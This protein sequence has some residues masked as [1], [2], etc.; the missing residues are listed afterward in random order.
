MKI[1]FVTRFL[2]YSA[3]R[4]SGAQDTYHYIAALSKDHDISLI[5][6]AS[7]E[8]GRATD[9]VR[10]ICRQVVT[11]PYQPDAFLPRLWRL[12]WRILLPRVYGRNVSINYWRSLR[13]LYSA[14][15][16][17][18]IVVDGMMAIYCYALWDSPLV[19]DEVDLYATV[20]HQNFGKE[21]RLFFRFLAWLDWRRTRLFEFHTIR[22][23]D[24]IFV[25]STKDRTLLH[26]FVPG[27]SIA[28]IGPWF[29]GLSE[30]QTIPLER[31]AGNNVLFIGAMHT[32]KNVE[33]VLYFAGEVLPLI[34]EKVP[35]AVFYVVGSEPTGS[36][37]DLN[38]QSNIVV[39]GEVESL[40]PYY[41]RCAVNVVPLLVGGGIIVKTLNGMAAGRPTV[42][43]D[44]GNSGIGAI[45]DRDLIISDL[46]P[47]KY[48][49]AVIRL[50]EDRLLWERLAS[51]GRHFIKQQYNWVDT[52]EELE[53]FLRNIRQQAVMN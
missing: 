7:P 39:T 45:S 31:P 38:Q 36:I 24:G 46:H 27:K 10:S 8:I 43:T 15:D 29:E 26:Q 50:L 47:E 13:N 17:D 20:A 9:D 2:P 14:G 11:V 30:L 48:A 40:S 3:A 6:F 51:N 28:V 12:G 42:T 1:L 34:Q 35:D 33:A 52:I 18:V 53:T 22:K 25:R 37:Q 44:A 49:A 19:L 5:G 23:C 4:D 41:E 21:R 16:F 32:P